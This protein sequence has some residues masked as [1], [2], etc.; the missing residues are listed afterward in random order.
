MNGSWGSLNVEKHI[1]RTNVQ[2]EMLELGRSFVTLRTKFVALER[3]RGWAQ[4][5]E[6]MFRLFFLPKR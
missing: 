1:S 6:V 3:P 2:M 5:N 4:T